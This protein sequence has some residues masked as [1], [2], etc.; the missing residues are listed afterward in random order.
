LISPIKTLGHP[1]DV[2]T[3]MFVFLKIA[4]QLRQKLRHF[5]YK[6]KCIYNISSKNKYSS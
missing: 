2:S 1:E 6:K 4:D 3:R 5:F